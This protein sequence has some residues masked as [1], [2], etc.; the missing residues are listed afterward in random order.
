MA[1][2]A[3]LQAVQM[4]AAF[5]YR[6]RPFLKAYEDHGHEGVTSS[7]TSIT[8]GRDQME[9]LRPPLAA[10]ARTPSS[11]WNIR[12]ASRGEPCSLLARPSATS[13]L[14]PTARTASS[15]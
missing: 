2:E 10:Y 11:S 15:R 13:P 12:A 7:E 5:R 8:D 3:C 1:A 9:G 6:A 4:T 14:V